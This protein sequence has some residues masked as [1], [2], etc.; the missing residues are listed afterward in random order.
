MEE[1]RAR[2][3]NLAVDV[4]W[5]YLNFF[6][7]DDAKLARIGEEYGA[8]RMLTGT[9]GGGEGAERGG[10][11]AST[12]AHGQDL[13]PDRGGRCAHALA[14]A[15]PCCVFKE[16]Q[17]RSCP[18]PAD[19]QPG[20][21]SLRTPVTCPRW[22]SVVGPSS[23]SSCIC[24]PPPKHTHHPKPSKGT[25]PSPSPSTVA[26]PASSPPHTPVPVRHSP[27]PPFSKHQNLNE[28]FPASSATHARTHTDMQ[29]R[30]GCLASAITPNNP[31]RSGCATP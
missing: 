3:A 16:Q 30:A 7:E 12:H 2:G 9:R 20:P 27:P 11:C 21:P 26:T 18:T 13:Q 28:A 10:G 25:A 31:R 5:K 23:A 19:S 8:G 15:F 14:C 6:M 17:T 4:P 22:C 1:H 29:E 24:W